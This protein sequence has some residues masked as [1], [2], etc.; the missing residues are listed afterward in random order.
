MS[1]KPRLGKKSR[2]VMRVLDK[3][4][5]TIKELAKRTK[6]TTSRVSQILVKLRQRSLVVRTN[7]YGPGA[8]GI[9]KLTVKGREELRKFGG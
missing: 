3:R 6:S 2:A 5:A 9:F 8:R 7:G 4:T 1:F